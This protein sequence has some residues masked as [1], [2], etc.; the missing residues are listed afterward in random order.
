MQN[1]SKI[2][3]DLNFLWDRLG[4]LKEMRFSRQDVTPQKANENTG[5]VLTFGRASDCVLA[6]FSTQP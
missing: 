2:R 3:K 4:A 1:L 5:S 6:K